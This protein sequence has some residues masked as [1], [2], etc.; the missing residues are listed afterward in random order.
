MVWLAVRIAVAV[1]LIVVPFGYAMAG[2]N[3]AVAVGAGCG[4]AI[5]A[6]VGL[7]GNRGPRPWTGILVGSLVGTAAVYMST[8]AVTSGAIAMSPVLALGVGLIHGE[9]LLDEVGGTSFSGYR[10][11][12]RETLFVSVLLALG[13]VP[14]IFALS[15]P[16][17]FVDIF[18][19]VPW[20]ALSAGLLS[21]RAAGWRDTRPPVL[22]VLATVPTVGYAGGAIVVGLIAADPGLGIGAGLG[23]AAGLLLLELTAT[24]AFF[25]FGRAAIIWC[26]PRFR[27]Y[28]GLSD[29]LRVMWV[30]IGGFVIGYVT[31]IILFAGFYG[32][33]EHFSPGAFAD[34]GTGIVDWLF[35]AFFAGL[36]QDFATIAPV[37]VGARALVGL[38]L[39]LSAG[40]VVVLFAAVMTSI[41]PKLERIA[42]RRAEESGDD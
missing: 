35:F 4:L 38:H 1:A 25:V 21:H 20:V 11:A 17:L 8:V 23:I 31:I 9:D 34:A 33:L 36:A 26:R 15:E 18:L 13:L 19:F 12:F 16:S 2:S 10:D 27:V 24:A 30:P 39:I 28:G 29:Y 14:A 22:L 42:R 41:G 3:A 32:T 37:S 5:G 40:W 6:A 7:S